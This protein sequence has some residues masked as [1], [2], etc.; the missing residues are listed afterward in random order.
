MKLLETSAFSGNVY[1]SFLKLVSKSLETETS[2]HSLKPLY[3]LTEAFRVHGSL[4]AVLYFGAILVGKPDYQTP[5][6]DLSM[7]LPGGGIAFHRCSLRRITYLPA[8]AQ[9]T[10]TAYNNT[11]YKR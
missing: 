1:G 6:L 2:N 7:K 4:Y 5:S 11:N 10:F 3:V 8:N 9:L